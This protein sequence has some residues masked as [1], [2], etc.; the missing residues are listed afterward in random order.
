MY[1][2]KMNEIKSIDGIAGMY[3]DSVPISSDNLVTKYIKSK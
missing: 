3:A 2:I 1:L